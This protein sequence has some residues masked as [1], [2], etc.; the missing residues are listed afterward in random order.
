MD[1]AMLKMPVRIPEVRTFS[2]LDLR[3][4]D[5]TAD[6]RFLEGLAVPYG[7]PTNVGWYYETHQKGEFAKSIKEAARGLPLLL[8]HNQGSWPVGVSAEWRDEDDGLH[9]VWRMDDSDDARRAVGL[10]QKG[11]LIGLSI[12]FQPIRSEWTFVDEDSWD[13]NGGP[14][15]MDRVTRLESRLFEVSLTPT[16]AFAGAQVQLVRS[17][18]RHQINHRPAATPN[19]ERAARLLARSRGEAA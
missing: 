18:D 12:G 1:D 10:A 7:V 4:A 6:G 17:A 19:R 11:V 8:F 14:D 3:E 5:S 9:G 13:P 2:A 15:G 16:P